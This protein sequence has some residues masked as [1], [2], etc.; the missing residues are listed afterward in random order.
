M[1]KP[2]DFIRNLTDVSAP[3]RDLILGGN[4]KRAFKL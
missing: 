4:A 2:T 3:D 1:T